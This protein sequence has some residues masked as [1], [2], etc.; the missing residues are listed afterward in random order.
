VHD[1]GEILTASPGIDASRASEPPVELSA[2]TALRG[3]AALTVLFF[4][5]SSLAL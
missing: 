4:H 2:L 3:L 1:A 5:S